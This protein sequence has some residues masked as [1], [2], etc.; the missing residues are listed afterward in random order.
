MMGLSQG[1]LLA[2]LACLALSAS[3]AGPQ[4]MLYEHFD[5]LDIVNLPGDEVATL[6]RDSQ[7]SPKLRCPPNVDMRTAYVCLL[8]QMPPNCRTHE[9]FTS[10][11]R[12]KEASWLSQ[13]AIPANAIVV[14]SE[15]HFLFICDL[16]PP[17]D[18]AR[19]QFLCYIVNRGT[20]LVSLK[21]IPF[22]PDVF[23]LGL[24]P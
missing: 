1:R 20:G 6:I 24:S 23:P 7:S 10:N 4:P 8:A 12:N 18:I 17:P 15:S 13:W 2:L 14:E 5:A 21:R 11:I 19:Q 16:G 9:R 22:S 3:C